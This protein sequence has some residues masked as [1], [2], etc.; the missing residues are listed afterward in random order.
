[1]P[2]ISEEARLRLGAG[3]I[4][5]SPGELN[6]IITLELLDYLDR[7]HETYK[8]INDIIG[9]LECAKQEF[10]RRIAVL[11]EDKKIKENG[12]VYYT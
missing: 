3:R 9:V 2:Y 4:A 5:T 12:D 1:M 10:Y 6:Y 11:Y 8:T 7:H